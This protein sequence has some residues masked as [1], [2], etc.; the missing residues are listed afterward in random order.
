MQPHDTTNNVSSQSSSSVPSAFSSGDSRQ[1]HCEVVRSG[2]LAGQP[3]LDRGEQREVTQHVTKQPEISCSQL[4][5]LTENPS[6]S[7][8][9]SKN[10]ANSGLSLHLEGPSSS[11]VSVRPVGGLSP[12]PGEHFPFG[13]GTAA[14]VERDDLVD[15]LDGTDDVDLSVAV[16]RSGRSMRFL[17]QSGAREL[18]PDQRV[19]WCLRRVLPDENQVEV[20]YSDRRGRA[21]Y[22]NLMVCGLLWGCPVCA[23][24]I[25]ETRR[26]ELSELFLSCSYA[27]GMITT[28]V[29][30]HREESFGVVLDRVQKSQA[31]FASGWWWQDF[32]ERFQIVGTLRALEVTYGDDHGWHPHQ[33]TLLFGRSVFTP[34]VVLEI[35]DRGSK[36]WAT[37]VDRYGGFASLDH[38]FDMKAGDQHLG[39]YVQKLSG[40]DDLEKYAEKRK[41]GLEHE[42]A[43]AVVKKGKQGGRTLNQLL[44][45]YVV[46]DDQRAGEL[47]KEA[48]LGLAGKKH[49]S[50]SHGLW[51][52][53]GREMLADEKAAMEEMSDMDRLLLALG[54]KEWREVCR[55]GKRGELLDI[56][57]SG[58]TEQ[59]L[60]FLF[61]LG[62]DVDK[63]FEDGL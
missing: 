61:S 17:L 5:T 56:A 29:S 37:L 28:T 44:Y 12:Q 4:G 27:M 15:D 8:G 32:K 22:R 57:D 6:V 33:H 59:V 39:D 55:Q 46:E 54:T 14:S 23:A 40:T 45:D 48:A 50:A 35:R 41:W 11:G 34:T 62:L 10:G 53:L 1:D 20:H 43:K 58:S 18:L 51:S 19:A 63:G 52:I 21:Y 49:L 13:G 26:R 38:G 42:V 24:A 25:S 7:V 31:A 2:G 3:G 9:G 60:S 16:G 47:W 36:K 30:H